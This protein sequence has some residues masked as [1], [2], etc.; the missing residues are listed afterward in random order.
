MRLKHLIVVIISCVCVYACN[1]SKKKHS[2]TKSTLPPELQALND[3]I[4]NDNKNPEL[5]YRRAVY[6]LN[7]KDLAGATDNMKVV[8]MLDSS[9]AKYYLTLGDI[10]FVQNNTRATRDLFLR[11]LKKQGSKLELHTKLAELYFYVQQYQEAL[12]YINLSLKEDVHYA[13]AYFLKGMIYKES[14]DTAKSVSSFITATEQDPQYYNAYMQLGILNALKNNPVC[15]DY[16]NNALRISPR[17]DEVHYNIGMFYMENKKYNKAIER[18][19]ILGKINPHNRE[20]FFN[21]GYIHLNFLNVKEQALRNFTDAIN[22]DNNYEKAY[23][24]R[25]YTFELMGDIA[26]AKRDYDKALNLFPDYEMAR[27]GLARVNKTK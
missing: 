23:Y 22:A 27:A 14:G 5:Y 3:S 4:L 21:L 19:T 15:L 9:K 2:E 13:K 1:S 8:M 16:Y 11:G 18:F 17:A 10:Y 24:M 6:S 7:H 20:A 25:G 26:A 12:N